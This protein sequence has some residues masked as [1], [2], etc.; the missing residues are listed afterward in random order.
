MVFHS[1]L[2]CSQTTWF[3]NKVFKSHTQK[4][5]N[6]TFIGMT[7]ELCFGVGITAVDTIKPLSLRRYFPQNYPPLYLYV[8]MFLVCQNCCENEKPGKHY[9]EKLATITRWW[10]LHLMSWAFNPLFRTPLW[11][12]YLCSGS[13]PL[14]ILQENLNQWWT[15]IIFIMFS[16][17]K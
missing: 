12:S 7:S 6:K 11:C 15:L 8:N 10:F 5:Q 17:C 1:S 2:L 4:K 13:S 14:L 16:Q 9:I 3:C